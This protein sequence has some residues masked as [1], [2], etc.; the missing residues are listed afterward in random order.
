MD[1]AAEGHLFMWHS[2]SPG[3]S[4]L[5]ANYDQLRSAMI[6]ASYISEAEFDQDIARLDDPSFMM[7]S[8]ILWT[9]WGRRS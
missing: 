6:E 1:V 3:V 7:P 5:R 2:G 8:P 4:L 9:A